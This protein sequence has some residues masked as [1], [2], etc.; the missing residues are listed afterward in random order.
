MKDCPVCGGDGELATS[1]RFRC[2]DCEGSGKVD[3]VKYEKLLKQEREVQRHR[4]ANLT[5]WEY[6]QMG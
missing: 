4:D 6:R 1:H 3:E 2:Y 5:A